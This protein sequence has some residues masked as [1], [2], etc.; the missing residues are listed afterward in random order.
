MKMFKLFLVLGVLL[1]FSASNSFAGYALEFDGVDDPRFAVLD[2]AGLD[3]VTECTVD[4]GFTSIN[5]TKTVLPRYFPDLVSWV[6]T[7]NIPIFTGIRI[8]RKIA[9]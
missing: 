8:H 6:T 5:K 7:M 1:A 3:G 2:A 4:T 9:V